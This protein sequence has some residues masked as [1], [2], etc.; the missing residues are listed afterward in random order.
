MGD[1]PVPWNVSKD[2]PNDDCPR[3]LTVRW[4]PDNPESVEIE[5]FTCGTEVTVRRED[6]EELQ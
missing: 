2:C 5:C 3:T 4:P 6:A 1:E